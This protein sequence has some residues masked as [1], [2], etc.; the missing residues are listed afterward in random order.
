VARIAKRI[1][2]G[3]GSLSDIGTIVAA[4]EG[5]RGRTICA[6]A[7]GLANAAISIIARFRWEFEEHVRMG[8]CPGG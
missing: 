2:A 1:E 5:M 6:L 7:D 4:A 8:R 3:E